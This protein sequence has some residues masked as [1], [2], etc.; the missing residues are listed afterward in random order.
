MFLGSLP[1]QQLVIG[2]P[3]WSTFGII[4]GQDSTNFTTT[5]CRQP[6]CCNAEGWGP[7][8]E[9]MADFTPCFLDLL[10]SLVAAFGV[11]F[12]ALS[13][14]SVAKRKNTSEVPKD[15]RF[16]TKLVSEGLV[17]PSPFVFNSPISDSPLSTCQTVITALAFTTVLQMM[18]ETVNWPHLW[19]DDLRLWTFVLVIA[20]L[21]VISAVQC[22][23]HTRL[24]PTGS[25]VVFYWLFVLLVFATKLRSLVLRRIYDENLPFFIDFCLSL[26][27][28]CIEFALV[29]LAPKRI[30]YD[31]LG[32][33]DKMNEA[34]SERASVFSILT[35]SWMTPMMKY[36]YKNYVTEDDLWN[37]AKRDSAGA[38]RNA[39]QDAW[40]F[41]LKHRKN[42]SLWI[43]LYRGFGTAYIQGVLF[44][45]GADVFSFVQPQLLRLLMSF[46]DSYRGH[47]PQPV[48]NGTAIAVG[49]FV[50]SIA[51]SLCLHQCFQWISQ[52]GIRL[53]SSLISSVYM[54]SLRLSNSARAEKSTG[55][56]VNLMAVDCQ[57]VQD[58]SQFGQHLWSAPLQIILCLGSLYQLLGYSMFAGVTIMVIMI[59]TNGLITTVTKNLQKQQ[60]KNKDARSRLI[61]EVLSN[62]KSIKLFGWGQAFMNRISHIRND[63]ELPTLRK[64]GSLQAISSFTGSVA[65]FLVA[66]STFAVYV[67]AQKKPLTTEIVFPALTL[68]HL[69]TSPLTVLPAAISAG[70]EASIAI[71]RLRAF[72]T[73]DEVQPDAVIRKETAEIGQESVVLCDATF[74]WDREENKSAL[75]DINFAAR[76]GQLCCL[77]GRVGAG[78]SSFIQAVLGDLYKVNGT[79]TTHGSI[80][81]AAQQAW[82]LNATVRENII[83]GYGWDSDFY[84]DTVKACALLDDFAQLPHGDETIV[85]DRGIQLSGGQKARLTLARAVYSRADI[86]L[87]DDCLS[88]VDQ[89]VGRH[90]IDNVLGPRGLLRRKTR[91]LATNS[92]SA[93]MEADVLVMIQDGKIRETGTYNQLKAMD[94]EFASLISRAS[95]SD[96]SD[97]ESQPD[98]DDTAAA[99]GCDILGQN[100]H[101]R[102]HSSNANRPGPPKKQPDVEMATSRTKSQKEIPRQGGVSWN[103]YGGY[104]KASNLFALSTYFIALLSAQTAELGELQSVLHL[105]SPRARDCWVAGY[106]EN[107]RI[108]YVTHIND[109]FLDTY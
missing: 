72:F 14:W 70:A 54:K 51:Q 39:F 68:F 20:S 45:T 106:P 5:A 18:F 23:E 29:W 52:T 3:S 92:I 95:N 93:M 27:L 33:N 66:C 87:L 34:P 109:T 102:R 53:K 28:V 35:F 41:E 26:G 43:A 32:D 30:V 75:E 104:A 67:L 15:W 8:S 98:S 1:S 91:I 21:L 10:I 50:V 31:A 107:V 86:Y 42:P 11:V 100:K 49:M 6:L 85:G 78:K 96:Q 69:L 77:V 16:W 103:I 44:K 4:N 99:N 12:G 101:T 80:A 71:G 83:F 17:Y 22:L 94:G 97:A 56:I 79:V 88:A 90:L 81:Y 60:M 36:G 55:D 61:A 64:I 108:S 40:K 58:A 65:P 37:L 9:V 47:E 84:E 73:A 46:I 24:Q 82:V 62:M 19:L 48:A 25:A 59:P 57:R 74:T 2:S 38:A 13:W 105:F 89:H 76:A 7:I 63:Q